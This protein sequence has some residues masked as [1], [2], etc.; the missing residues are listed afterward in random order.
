VGAGISGG[1]R[2]GAGCDPR[3]WGRIAAGPRGDAVLRLGSSDPLQVWAIAISA[4]DKV[5]AA[6]SGGGRDLPDSGL[7]R[8]WDFAARKQVAS[9]ATPT[10]ALSVDLSPDGKRVS[11]TCWS[12]EHRMQEIGGAELVRDKYG[13]PSRTAFSPDGELLVAGAEGTRHNVWSGKTGEQREEFLGDALHFTWFGFSPDSK[14]LVAG[15]RN[16]NGEAFAVW[17]VATRRQLYVESND[18]YAALFAAISP[19]SKTLAT[20]GGSSIVFRD[21]ATGDRTG[22]TTKTTRPV[23][24]IA[25][26]PDGSLLASAGGDQNDGV[27]TLWDVATRKVAD[28]LAGDARDVRALAFTHDGKTLATGGADRSI[29]LWDVATRKQTQVLQEPGGSDL[30]KDETAAILALPRS[31]EPIDPTGE[32]G[33]FFAVAYAPDGKSVAGAGEDGRVS[34]YGLAAA[35][36]QRSWT[37][38]ADAIGALAYSPDG[39]TLVSGGFDKTIKF[40]N[41]TSGEL[42]RTLAG[43]TGWVMSLAFSHDGQTLA[44]GSYDRSIRLWN[45]A[46]GSERMKLSG[47]T[48]SA[49]ALAFSHDDK[50]LAS[51]SA[52]H[53]VRLWDVASG[54]Q[55]AVLTG[56]EGAVRGVAFAPFDRLL[57]SG[58]EDQKIKLWSVE[59]RQLVDTLTGHTD[60]VSAVAFARGTLVSAGWD[61]RLRTWDVAE[62]KMH[63]ELDTDFAIAAMAVAPGGNRLLT[64]GGTS[65]ALWQAQGV[66]IELGTEAAEPK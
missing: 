48:G 46:D 54:Q 16:G 43:H 15:G 55:Q 2:I 66:V 65:L 36:Q 5:L 1:R 31:R 52:D 61:N 41:P 39:Q 32:T 22:E 33:G 27:V 51:G 12:G 23:V 14:Y 24:R 17:D 19:D 35:G 37:A 63:S 53:T 30:S 38:H 25:F 3:A 13:L 7:V 26:S 34:V 62:G 60:A 20:S 50:L 42:V 58:A 10:G 49:R 47:H 28:R 11:W 4:D 6:A 21:L 29:R 59:S 44:S 40:W 64:A 8:V 45:V 9:Y 18:P 57:A 56:H